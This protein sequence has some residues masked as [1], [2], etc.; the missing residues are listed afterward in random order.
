[1]SSAS[2]RTHQQSTSVVRR[3]CVRT[4]MV[5]RKGKRIREA[6]NIWIRK[7]DVYRRLKRP[8]CAPAAA[9]PVE[10]AHVAPRATRCAA[11]I[12]KLRTP[13]L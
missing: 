6:P 4:R 13:T 10:G 11:G 7:P 9:A 8:S 3:N 5:E 1:V 2:E 12:D